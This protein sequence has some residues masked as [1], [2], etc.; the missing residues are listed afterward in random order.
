M[1]IVVLYTVHIFPSQAYCFAHGIV[2]TVSKC[3]IETLKNKSIG[4]GKVTCFLF[5]YVANAY[6]FI[7]LLKSPNQSQLKTNVSEW[8]HCRT[9]YIAAMKLLQTYSS[10]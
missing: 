4:V 9:F 5:C 6:G 2:S 7:R 3:I 1:L 8:V 10:I